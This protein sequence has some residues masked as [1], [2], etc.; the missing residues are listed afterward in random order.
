V[1]LLLQRCGLLGHVMRPAPMTPPG[2]WGG[3][4]RGSPEGDCH[5]S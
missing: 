3:E 5:D 4:E 2:E 1:V